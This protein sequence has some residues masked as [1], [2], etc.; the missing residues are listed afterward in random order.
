LSFSGGILQLSD[1]S[2]N[3]G[4]VKAKFFNVG[5]EFGIADT[6][7]EIVIHYFHKFKDLILG[8]CETHSLE[9]VV[10]L[11]DLDVV[12]FVVVNLL[13]DLLEG[14]ASLFEYLH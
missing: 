5:S 9:H 8:N 11:I 6:P 4:N 2:L 14:E 1:I 3:F 7:I 13:K 12:V 10:E